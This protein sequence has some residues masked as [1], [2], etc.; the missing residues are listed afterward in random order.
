MDELKELKGKKSELDLEIKELMEKRSELKEKI[1]EKQ[2]SNKKQYNNGDNKLIRVSQKFSGKMDFINDE[3]EKNGFDL[4]SS[5]KITELI[6]KHHRWFIIENDLIRF[7]TEIE[8]VQVP[9]A[10]NVN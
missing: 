3:R 2:K 7:D 8:N 9:E 10:V 5:P 4:L 1:K 6:T